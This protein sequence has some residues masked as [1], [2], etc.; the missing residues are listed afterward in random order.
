ML[1][2]MSEKQE[3]NFL[4]FMA[5]ITS[6]KRLD[7]LL[8]AV[9]EELPLLVG[10]VGCWIYLEPE[11]LLGFRDS[12]VR[13]NKKYSEDEIAQ[14]Y[15]SFIVLAATNVESKK[16]LLRKAFFGMGEG[17]T[18]WVYK[19]GRTLRISD[20]RD[21]EELASISNELRWAN[22][23]HDGDEFYVSSLNEK[24]PLLAVPLI[25]DGK[26]IGTLKFHATVDKKPYSDVSEKIAT[27]AA[28]IIAGV[29]RQT[30]MISE[31]NETI[32]RLIEMS[33]KNSY[34]EVISDVTKSLKKMLI[35]SRSEF[36]LK[37]ES[38]E[39]LHLIMRDGIPQENNTLFQSGQSLVGWVYKTGL[40]L[41][42]D[43]IKKFTTRIRLDDDLLDKISSGHGK[44][45]DD[46]RFL[47]CEEDFSYYGAT[48]KLPTL[49]F[50]AVP[51]KSVDGEVEG[52]LC[53]YWNNPSKMQVVS[54]PSQ[55]L[56]ALSF[57]NTIALSL[58]DRRQRDTGELLK[59]LGYITQYD[60]LFKTVVNRIP[61]L[62][63]SSGCSIFELVQNRGK[64][65][66]KLR[67]TSRKSLIH[68]DT[69][70]PD[71]V[72]EL[73]EGKTGICGYTQCVVI[74][75][76]FGS[77]DLSDT[78]LNL[79]YERINRSYPKDVIKIVSDSNGKKVGLVQLQSNDILSSPERLKFL[80]IANTIIFD[81]KGLVSSKLEKYSADKTWSYIAVPIIADD[82]LLGVITLARPIPNTPFLAKD[83]ELIK[84]I[85]GRLASYMS[86]LQ[87]LENYKKLVM[88][89]AHETNTPLV[90]IMADSENIYKE[91]LP[92]SDLQ[93]IAKHNL[94][95][96]LRLHMQ[97]STIMS[98][99]SEQS[100][101][102]QFSEHSIYRPLIEACELFASEAA[103]KGCD[104]LEPRAREGVFPKIEMSLFDMTIAIKNIIH[105]AVKYSFKP[106]VNLD[107]HRTIKVWGQQSKE[108]KGHYD[109]FVQNYGVE[110]TQS[111]IESRAIFKPFRR[112]EKASDKRRIGAGFGLAH[113]LMV[114]E[115]L[116]KGSIDVTSTHQGGDAYLTTFKISL[117]IKH[118]Y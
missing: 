57:A 14:A 27:I 29:L 13:G 24:R 45:N 22:E 55:L 89:L 114:I 83:V 19:N 108:K 59:D 16:E 75:N 42:I 105:N 71:I 72:Y 58:E 21:Q 66:L 34:L 100:P 95:Q 78:R 116:H 12:L 109:I 36:Y 106:P 20:I 38:G 3:K 39:T 69:T 70:T 112:G 88:T 86:N 9:V 67:Y 63:S 99:L 18:G 56:L 11:Y 17:I 2:D 115:E 65:Q 74:V 68:N 81:E 1:G 82:K 54:D 79:E 44:I 107:K 64:S 73:G 8:D 10:A 113:A 28:N 15:D 40:P 90:G 25:L 52:V 5:K 111:E 30:W 117:P 37:S 48:G 4:A 62:V 103:Q 101:E 118:P 31:Q 46:D 91:C 94:E 50:M 77:G 33:N 60:Q 92:D 80:A 49:S 85:S 76:H 53:G 41:V 23:Y 7:N 93:K 97:T 35:C 6:I 110:I 26:P 51:V 47:V 87:T 61:L 102:R 32:T 96:V 104:I 84:S 43:N 98:V